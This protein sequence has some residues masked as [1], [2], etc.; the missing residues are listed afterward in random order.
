MSESEEGPY[1]ACPEM[2][3]LILASVWE[4]VGDLEPHIV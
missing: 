3:E 4:I 1:R 2:F